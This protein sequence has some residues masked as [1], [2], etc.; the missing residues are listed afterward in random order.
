MT[1]K[2]ARILF[3]EYGTQLRMENDDS[4]VLNVLCG[5]VAQYGIAFRL[6]NDERAQYKREGDI[7]IQELAKRVQQDPKRFQSRGWTC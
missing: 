6:N 4:L 5:T 7:F 2:P 1:E 3:H